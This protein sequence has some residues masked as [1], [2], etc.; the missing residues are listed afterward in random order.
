MKR[1]GQVILLKPE[2]FEDYKTYHKKVWP[3]VLAMIADCNIRK[4]TIYHL[5]GFLFAHFE[6]HGNDFESDMV[7][8]AAHPKTQEWWSIMKPM[9]Q[10]LK[11]TDD[12]EWWAN[13]EE[14]FFME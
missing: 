10:P 12:G 3:E 8:M 13:M 6:Y 14:V 1:Y 11:T 2:K 4:Y 5:D 7:K 9:Q